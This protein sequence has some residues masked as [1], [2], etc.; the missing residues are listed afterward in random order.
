MEDKNEI[1]NYKYIKTIGEGT[2]G[3]VKLAVHTLTGEKVAIKILRKKLIKGKNEYNR[4]E[5]EIKY[6]K[7]FNHPNIIQIYE[8]IESSSSFY[9]VMEY[10]PGGELFNYIVEK[11]KLPENESSFY[12]YQI[13]QGIKEIHQKKICHRD[14]KPENLLFTKNKI[15]KIIDFGLSSE[16]DDYLSTPCG[17]P[18]YASP[19]MIKGKKYNGLSIDLWACGIILF[20]MLCG[21]LPFDDKNNNELFRKIVECKIDYPEKDEVELSETSLDLINKI[22]TPNPKERIGIEEILEHPF[23]KY[24]K[25][26]YNNLIKPDNFNQEE[27][28]INY[29]INELGFTNK[30]NIIEKYIHSNRHNYITTTFNLLKQK[31][32]EGRLNYEYKEKVIKQIAK[33]DFNNILLYK[34]NSNNNMKSNNNDSKSNLSN[35]SKKKIQFRNNFPFNEKIEN[36]NNITYNNFN[37]KKRSKTSSCSQSKKNILSLKD[38]ITSKDL[39]DRNNIIIINNTNMIQQSEKMK[40]IYNNLFFKNEDSQNQFFRKIETSVSLE[41]SINKNNI[42]SNNNT[43]INKLDVTYNNKNKNNNIQEKIKVCLKKNEKMENPYIYFKKLKDKNLLNKKKFIY[44]PSQNF[45]SKSNNRKSQKN[46]NINYTFKNDYLTYKKNSKGIGDFINH[47]NNINSYDGNNSNIFNSSLSNNYLNA[48]SYDINNFNYNKNSEYGAAISS[49][50]NKKNN[51]KNILITDEISNKCQFKNKL[52]NKNSDNN[53]SNTIEMKKENTEIINKSYLRMKNKI[54]LNNK[55]KNIENIC[56]RIFKQNN[57]RYLEY[58]N[59]NKKSSYDNQNK[60]KKRINDNYKNKY[61]Y[62]NRQQ[63]IRDSLNIKKIKKEYIYPS[64]SRLDKVNKLINNININNLSS[65]IIVKNILSKKLN[66]NYITKKENEAKTILENNF[67]KLKKIIKN[68]ANISNNF[69]KKLNSE[70]FQENP[71]KMQKKIQTLKN[72]SPKNKNNKENINAFS[73]F[74]KKNKINKNIKEILSLKDNFKKKSKNKLNNIQNEKELIPIV[75]SSRTNFNR[76]TSNINYIP[77]T[78]RDKRLY[79]SRNQNFE[80]NNEFSKSNTVLLEKN[81]LLQNKLLSSEKKLLNK[82]KK[83]LEEKYLSINI[84]MNIYQIYE[85]LQLFCIENNLKCINKGKNNFMILDK[86]MGDSFMVEIIDSSQ[87]SK[88]NIVKFSH[89]KNT[90]AKMIEIITKILFQISN[91]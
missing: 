37:F 32:F 9:I 55:V 17:S 60:E 64:T 88:M 83:D 91:F 68:N 43:E 82:N 54:N 20:A 33:P 85:K 87:T 62:T 53:L 57:K 77:I 27:L 75:S 26:A 81:K 49:S 5:R 61:I 25:K 3:K 59:N 66:S 89:G 6:L 50:R 42:T 44:L 80:I 45:S 1:S 48:I 51:L 73:S 8:V 63:N 13:I 23:M 19:E 84:E 86:N 67:K 38:M 71:N 65:K 10:A 7:L 76:L 30:N 52:L 40:P 58:I 56:K 2:F 24:G 41:K 16:Y 74:I 78:S 47:F 18:C 46:N 22:L 12:F 29:M 31:Y 79:V 11:E 21:Y 36:H 39:V 15:L 69:C 72:L 28:I 34:R 4:I 35:Y 90:S 14:V 70:S